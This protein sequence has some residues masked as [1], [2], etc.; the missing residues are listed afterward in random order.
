MGLGYEYDGV[1][2]LIDLINRL[3]PADRLEAYVREY[4]ATIAANARLPSRRS[5]PSW[6]RH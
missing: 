2:K 5:R 3:L 1:R 6:S 4:A